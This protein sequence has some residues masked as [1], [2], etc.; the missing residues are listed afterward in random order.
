MVHGQ[1]LSGPRQVNDGLSTI[2]YRL[3]GNTRGAVPQSKRCSAQRRGE[4][5]RLI[6][7]IYAVRPDGCE[8]A[9]ARVAGMPAAADCTPSTYLG[10]TSGDTTGCHRPAAT[11]RPMSA[12]EP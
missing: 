11:V 3:L 5:T 9:A 1:S 10:A 12:S 2:D 8:T 4:Q 7:G 6:A